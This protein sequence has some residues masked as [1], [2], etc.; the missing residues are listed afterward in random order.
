MAFLVNWQ[1]TFI[2]NYIKLSAD[3]CAILGLDFALSEIMISNRMI[4]GLR[5]GLLLF[6][7]LFQLNSFDAI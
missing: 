2:D 4:N 6:H 1:K 3:F 7:L 5:S